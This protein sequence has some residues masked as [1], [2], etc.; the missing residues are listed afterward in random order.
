MQQMRERFPGYWIQ[1]AGGFA[2]CCGSARRITLFPTLELV[3][4]ARYMNCGRGCDRQREPH[5][6]VRVDAPPPRLSA[7]YRRMVEAE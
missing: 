6:G 2:L 5:T 7:S 4:S 3:Q 1:G